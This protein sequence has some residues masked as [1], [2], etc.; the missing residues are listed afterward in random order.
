MDAPARAA[1]RRMIMINGC[2]NCANYVWGDKK[3]PLPSECITCTTTHVPNG[4]H[5]T[6]SHWKAKPQTN[7]D[8]IRAM[9]DEELAVWVT[10]IRLD[11]I[12]E[13]CEK[14]DVE[15]EMPAPTVENTADVCEWLKQPAE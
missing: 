12:N 7:A 2:G 3:T 8:L 14:F 15:I 9:S 10:S 6:P 5:P 11:T 13:M 4:Q 1:E